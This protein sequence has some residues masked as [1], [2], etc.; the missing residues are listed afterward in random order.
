MSTCATIAPK[1]EGLRRVAHRVDEGGVP[2]ALVAHPAYGVDE[3][4]ARVLEPLA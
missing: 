2:R 1:G 4:L 3:L